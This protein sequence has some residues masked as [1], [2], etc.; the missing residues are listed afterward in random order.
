MRRYDA[1]SRSLSCRRQDARC[2]LNAAACRSINGRRRIAGVGL[3]ASARATCSK[4]A[5]PERAGRRE[6]QRKFQRG[7]GR[8]L[9]WLHTETGQ[10]D[11]GHCIP[12]IASAP[13]GSP[14][15]SRRWPRPA[16]PIRA[17][18][19][20]RSCT[21]PCA[22]WHRGATGAGWAAPLRNPAEPRHAGPRQAAAPAPRRGTGRALAGG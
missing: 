2:C 9:T 8:W 17:W 15:M 19:G 14:P 18:V 20:S 7:Y 5:G 11:S 12:A 3:R 4:R 1:G 21:P 16:R 6:S 10:L 13:R 22:S